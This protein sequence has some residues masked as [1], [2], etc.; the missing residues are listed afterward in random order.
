ME[1]CKELSVKNSCA[2]QR[3]LR[4]SKSEI[5]IKVDGGCLNFQSKEADSVYLSVPFN[6]FYSLLGSVY[7]SVP[8]NLFYTLLGSEYLKIIPLVF[9][10]YI[11][12]G[13]VYLRV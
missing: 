1:N 9:S 8:F 13:S 12:L 3:H 7:L 2:C 6:L 5:I 4:T 11:P 10:T